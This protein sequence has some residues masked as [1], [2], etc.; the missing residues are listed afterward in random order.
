MTDHAALSR[1]LAL[2]IGYAPDCV[3]FR[4][5]GRCVVY[6]AG[7]TSGEDGSCKWWKS[8]SYTDPTVWGPVLDWLMR[9]HGFRVY[10][11]ARKEANYYMAD[12]DQIFGGPS[13]P[14]AVARAAISLKEQA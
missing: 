5:D 7:S 10:F 3:Q 4:G 11:N 6:G 9:K 1:E 12:L 13:L 14:E 2:A 8:F